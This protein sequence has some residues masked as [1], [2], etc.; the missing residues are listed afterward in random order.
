MLPAYCLPTVVGPLTQLIAADSL[1][2]YLA[3]TDF[4]YIAFTGTTTGTYT[5]SNGASIAFY[6]ENSESYFG[7]DVTISVTTYSITEVAGTFSGTLHYSEDIADQSF[8]GEFHLPWGVFFSGL[9]YQILEAW[10]DGKI[11]FVVSSEILREYHRVGEI[12]GEEFPGVDVSRFLELLTVNRKW[13]L[14]RIYQSLSVLILT[15]IS[16]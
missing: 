14:L 2:E 11:Q 12:L 13:L 4:W 6:L 5:S 1:A 8:Q 10:R 9:P 15:M 7:G 3:G 16:F